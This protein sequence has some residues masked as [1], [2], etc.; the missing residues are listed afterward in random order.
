MRMSRAGGLIAGCLAT[1]ALLAPA[2]AQAPLKVWK[3]GI[4]QAKSDAGIVFMMK[5]QGFDKAE[6][7]NVDMVQFTGDA[8]ALKALLAGEL[9]SYEGS[10]GAPLIAASRGA[11]LKIVGCYWPG[12]TYAIF[13][14]Q[15]VASPED[16]KGKTLAL[17]SP[18]A[19][20]DL[21][22]RAVLEKYHIAQGDVHFAAMGSD[23]D[24][25]R[26]LA[27]G[28]VDA[29]ALSTEFT[30]YAQTQNVKLLVHAHDVA[31]DY[32]R[33]CTTTTG[34]TIAGKGDELSHFLAAQMQGAAY[35]L[36][37]RDESIALTHEA[38]KTPAA[39]PRAADVFDEVQK[40]AAVDPAMPIPL[41]KLSWMQDLLIRTGNMKT[42]NDFAKLVD[43]APR[44]AALKLVPATN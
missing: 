9:D 20:P 44:E 22:A 11:D 8:L 24:R 43:A 39:D 7:L 6:G 33:F 2:S 10:P 4:V 29:A 18:G 31:P 12:V 5:H 32:L 3:H 16:L 19:L 37:H 14:K 38:T 13:S 27:A 36:A 30:R 34:R 26:A 1:W 25:M 40:Y 21:I 41:D 28:V 15:S 42:K 23:T 17:S 35:A